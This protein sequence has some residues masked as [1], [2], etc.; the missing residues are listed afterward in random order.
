M[1]P[2]VLVVDD[3]L[4]VRMDLRGALSA[5][6]F[7][8]TTCETKREAEIALRERTFSLAVLDV[9]LPD[10]SGIELLGMIRATERLAFLPVMVLS[11]EAE[12]RD[13]VKGLT[14]GA[15]EY[16]GKPY[17]ITYL[18]QRARSL[19]A[20]SSDEESGRATARRIL[21]VDDSP[22]FLTELACKLREDGHDVVLARSGVEALEL[23]AVQSVDCV[24]LD[25][26]MPD[27]DGIETLRRL[28]RLP[29]RESTPTVMLTAS[30]DP[31][32]A[33]RATDAGASDFVQKSVDLDSVRAKIRTLLRNR[34]AVQAATPSTR[35]QAD[36][37]PPASR[38]K[39]AADGPLLPRIIAAM[40]LSPV[41]ARSVLSKACSRAG[42]DASALC[43]EGLRRALPC[44]RE[45]LHMF[46]QADEVQRRTQAV[47]ALIVPAEHPEA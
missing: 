5:A 22:T 4:T 46:Y 37:R 33:V 8:V 25:V 3:S 39:P 20:R 13:R 34:R 41:L 31:A 29:G 11:T 21:A 27:V 23:L 18:I 6:G 12:V 30:E 16:V 15:D 1:K 36:E 9:I 2:H 40:G 43:A 24:I 17:D 42:V 26:V 7:A 19:C 14:T 45:A 47:A 38:P 10:G 28:R 35:L 44:I 32:L